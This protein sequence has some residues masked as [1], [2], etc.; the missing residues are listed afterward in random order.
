[1]SHST[2]ILFPPG[3]GIALNSKPQPGPPVSRSVGHVDCAVVVTIKSHTGNGGNTSL[4][5]WRESNIGQIPSFHGPILF[6]T[7]V[8]I[9]PN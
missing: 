5:S 8:L 9:D 6:W 1:M 2:G 3:G 4:Q 7:D